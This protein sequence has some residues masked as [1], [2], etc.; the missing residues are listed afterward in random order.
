MRGKWTFGL[1][2]ALWLATLVVMA[3]QPAD[4]LEHRL[5]AEQFHA[6][7][8]DTLSPAQ[9]AL[10][11][12]LLGKQPPAVAGNA[13]RTDPGRSHGFIGVDDQ[14]SKSRLK[15]ATGGWEPGTVFEL[16]NGQQWKVLKG[17][18]TFYK[19]LQAPDIV[20]VPGIAGRWFLRFDE[21]TPMARV[22]RID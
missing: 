15:G 21:D 1:I 19:P 11:N 2:L 7:G 12:Q 9:L 10:L 5:T 20:L 6:T 16:D 22:Y 18:F 8:L 17:H 13:S 4:S 14:P 3:Q